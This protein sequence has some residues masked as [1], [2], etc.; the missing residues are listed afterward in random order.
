MRIPKRVNA[1]WDWVETHARGVAVTVML[2]GVAATALWLPAFATAIAG[3][4]AGALA[5]HTRM[6]ARTE[7]LRAEI[8]DLLRENG[9]LR[10][11]QTVLVKGAASAEALS[12]LKLPVIHGDG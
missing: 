12:T 2:V 11:Q 8:D 4:L 10:H 9:S 7:R 3:A 5:V 6:S 1:A